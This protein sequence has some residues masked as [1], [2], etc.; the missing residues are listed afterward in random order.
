ML[1]AY[2]IATWDILIVKLNSSGNAIW[3]NKYDA[4]GADYVNDALQ[5]SDGNYVV[6]CY[7]TSAGNGA[8]DVFL[9][10][11]TP[12]GNVLWANSYGGAGSEKDPFMPGSMFQQTADNGFLLGAQTDSF[13]SGGADIYLVKTD[14]NGNTNNCHETAFNYIAQSITTNSVEPNLSFN[15]GITFSNSATVVSNFNI[16][17]QLL[18]PIA[19]PPTAAF[20]APITQ[21]CVNNC[22]NFTDQ[23][24]DNPTAWLWTFEGA[25]PATSSDQNPGNICYSEAGTYGVQLIVLNNVGS[26]TLLMDNYVNISDN[27][28]TVNNVAICQGDSLFLQGYYQHQ[29]GI[30]YDTIAYNNTCDT[31]LQTNLNVQVCNDAHCAFLL[32][33]AFSPNNDKVNDVFLPQTNCVLNSYDLWIYNRWGEQLFHTNN[34]S[35]GWDGTY[36]G[37]KQELGVYA[38]YAQY[39]INTENGTEETK[40]IKGNVTLVR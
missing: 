23:S 7:T 13:G 8:E 26:D 17:D 35:Y 33:N 9:A 19:P 36:K 10:K 22:L 38:F 16:L 12:N 18:C 2:F 32:P 27:I 1:W 34:L 24:S 30:Y 40:T 4:G 29:T 39:T 14:A 20:T 37:I 11:F 5:T 6:S 15:S 31:I 25:T 21:T 3:A 28:I